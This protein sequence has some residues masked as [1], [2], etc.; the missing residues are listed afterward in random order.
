MVRRFALLAAVAVGL[1]SF[2]PGAARPTAQ[3]DSAT[4]ASSAWLEPVAENP[5]TPEGSEQAPAWLQTELTDACSGDTFALKDFVGKTVFIETMA[6]WC[7]N[8][9][10]QLGRLT[11]AAAM[12]PAADR[13]EIVLVVLSSEVDLPT[14]DLAAYA[15]EN[16]FPFVFAVMPTEMLKTM[17]DDLG[18]EIAV[19]PAT[20]H[21]IVMPDGTIGE[22]HTGTTSPEELLALLAEAGAISAS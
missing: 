22:L 16:S 17:V 2:Q 18:Q 13:D 7:P 3:D 8:C 11:E 6:T 19:P 20:P 1:V 5:A 9:H 21:L 4:C 14:Q 15:E 12:V 10:A